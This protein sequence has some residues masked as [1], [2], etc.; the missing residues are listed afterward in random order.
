MPTSEQA[1][2]PVWNQAYTS[3]PVIGVTD[4]KRRRP[5]MNWFVFSLCREDILRQ[6][7]PAIV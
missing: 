5:V 4:A 2:Y 3:L 6:A 1:S 7:T